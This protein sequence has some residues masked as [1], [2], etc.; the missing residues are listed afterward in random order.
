VAV[1]ETRDRASD[2]V[3][4]IGRGLGVPGLLDRLHP[5]RGPVD[6]VALDRVELHQVERVVQIARRHES[7]PLRLGEVG[8][9]ARDGGGRHEATQHNPPQHSGLLS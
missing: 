8:V 9:R 5:K 1:V 3:V 4:R 7:E 6:L 2:G